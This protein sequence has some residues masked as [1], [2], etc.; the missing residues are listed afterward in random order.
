[1]VQIC[2]QLCFEGLG[3]FDRFDHYFSI[4]LNDSKP[5]GWLIHLPFN[6]EN[7]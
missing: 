3:Q 2:L 4:T 6:S 7:Y 5:K 1:M